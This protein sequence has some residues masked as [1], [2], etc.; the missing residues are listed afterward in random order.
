MKLDS[1]TKF[2]IVMYVMLAVLTFIL[3]IKEINGAWLVVSFLNIQIAIDEYFS[4]KILKAKDMLIEMQDNLI[5]S[6]MKLKEK[7]DVKSR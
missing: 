7:K 4:Y 3:G 5:K 2:F 1:K 6:I